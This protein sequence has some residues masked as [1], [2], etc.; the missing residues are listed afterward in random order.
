MSWRAGCFPQVPAARFTV[1]VTGTLCPLA[2]G[3]FNVHIAGQ[4]YWQTI[5]L[6]SDRIVK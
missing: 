2:W 3:A 5:A 4:A 1:E 6:L